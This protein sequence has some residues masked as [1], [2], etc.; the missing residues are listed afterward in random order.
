MNKVVPR[1]K[2]LQAPSDKCYISLPHG[3][4][5]RPARLPSPECD[6]IS[7]S[8]GH[9]HREN[10]VGA[11]LPLLP[12][13][14]VSGWVRWIVDPSLIVRRKM[15]TMRYGR[16]QLYVYIPH[17]GKP[18]IAYEKKVERRRA[19]QCCAFAHR[20]CLGY[21]VMKLFCTPPPSRVRTATRKCS[22]LMGTH[23]EQRRPVNTNS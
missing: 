14:A 13:E 7:H 1:S 21:Q 4:S 20:R 5:S 9:R 17:S 22:C 12:S 10:V 23:Q 8:H 6:N 3:S 18:L 15:K 16:L 19:V 2:R 11:T